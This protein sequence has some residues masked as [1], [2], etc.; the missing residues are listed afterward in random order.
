L[1]AAYQSDEPAGG[2]PALLPFNPLSPKLHARRY[3]LAGCIMLVLGLA[4]AAV[5]YWLGTRSADLTDNTAMQGYYKSESHQMGVL[6][7]KQGIL[8]DDLTNDLKKP[9]TQACL[10][11]AGSV[12]AAIGCFIFARFP[13]VPE[14]E[15]DRE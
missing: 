10:I 2:P 13:E 8:I 4:A 1:P 3:K 12:V 5:V 15:E 11:I 6:Y 14:N 9:G 7:G